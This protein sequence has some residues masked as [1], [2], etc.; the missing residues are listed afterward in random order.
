MTD[1]PEDDGLIE[2]WCGAAGPY[3][4]MFDSRFLDIWCG[5]SGTLHCYCG[6]DQCVCHHH[7]EARCPGCP[8]CEPSEG[9]R[10]LFHGGR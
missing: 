8:D 4:D 2:C 9:E 5:G 6:G 10:E 1:G 3:E 7:G